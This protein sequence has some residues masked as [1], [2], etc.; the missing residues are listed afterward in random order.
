MKQ[1]GPCA[2]SQN[3]K[4][5][6]IPD[7]AEKI[8]DFSRIIHTSYL[9]LSLVMG[10]EKDSAQIRIA[11]VVAAECAWVEGKSTNGIDKIMIYSSYIIDIID[12][13]GVL[14]KNN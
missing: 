4:S 11:V 8:F 10:D 9:A 12:H 7:I 1:H 2:G 14:I 6:S 3:I 13:K 5:I